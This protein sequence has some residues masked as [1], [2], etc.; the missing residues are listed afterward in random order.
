M[1]KI[2][3]AEGWKPTVIMVLVQLI[4]AWMNIFLK[5]AAHDGMDL[6]VAVTYRFVFGAASLVPVA[7]FFERKV[8][9]KLTCKVVFFAFLSGLFGGALGQNLYLE[10]LVL[11]SVTFISAMNNLV[12]AT[13]FLLAVSLRLESLKWHTRA[14]KAKLLGTIIGIGGAML[15]TFY[16]GPNITIWKTDVNILNIMSSHHRH[17]AS[18]KTQGSNQ[19]L[20]SILA[21]LCCLSF[22]LWLIFQGKAAQC[23]PC[24]LSFAAVM[25]VMALVLNLIA[26]SCLQRDWKEWKLGWNIRLIAVAFSGLLGTTVVYSLITIAIAMR[27]PLFVSAFNPLILVIVAIVGSLVLE[28][29]LHLGSLLGGI[30]IVC[31]LYFIC[32]GKSKESKMAD[33]STVANEQIQA[34]DGMD[35]RVAVTYRFIFGAVTMVPI[36]FFVERKTRPKLT[37]KVLFFAFLSGLFGGSLGQNLF[38]ESLVLTSAT[39]TSAM[40]NLIPA[41]TF[42]LSLCLRLE[43][44]NWHARAGKAKVFGTLIGIG[45][46][47]LFTFY[48]GPTM[49]IWK[50]DVNILN[51]MPSHHQTLPK[52]QGSDQVLGAI[53]AFLCCIS[54]SLW[55]IFQAKGAQ[56]Y[57]CPLSFTALMIVMALVSNLIATSCLQR[58]WNQWKL[59]WDIRLFA[60][61][62]SVSSIRIVGIRCLLCISELIRAIFAGN[63]WYNIVLYPNDGN[64][65]NERS[66]ICFSFQ[67]FVTHHCG[68]CW[69]T[70]DGRE[71]ILRKLAWRFSHNMWFIHHMLGEEPRD[72][73][74]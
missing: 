35:L 4:Y 62:F 57:P 1:T 19:I 32:W 58:D 54:F 39:F 52:A 66:I 73:N 28:E 61:A 74:D 24:P 26:T 37:W 13:T 21:F 20:G 38:L 3:K 43:R 17:R 11:T 31:S 29:D 41:T 5:L 45:G 50:T 25:V 16:K 48:K 14:G 10:S 68:R 6:R 46:A 2:S 9:P 47:M 7:F 49:T 64:Y 71:I 15:F 22:S 36:A 60:V 23:Y 70:C 55:F 63:F 30:L 42:L 34:H 8:R 12:P 72:Y 65:S 51:I 59:G 53:L 27:G 56:H 44:L 69:I 67:P 40:V 18:R 33:N